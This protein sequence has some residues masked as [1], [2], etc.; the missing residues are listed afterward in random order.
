KSSVEQ[1]RG[2]RVA[3]SD[4][5]VSRNFF[6]DILELAGI[7]S[8]ELDLQVIDDTKMVQLARAGSIDYAFPSGAAQGIEIM[9]AG[10]YRVVGLEQFIDGLPPGSP[11]IANAIGFSGLQTADEWLEDNIE[12]MLRVISVFLRIL[13]LVK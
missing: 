13:D 3:V 9:K 10:F 4:E 11:Q 1:I 5:G 6:N 8:D 7:R 12:T 2:Q